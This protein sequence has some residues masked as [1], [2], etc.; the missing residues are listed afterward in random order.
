[1]R[2]ASFDEIQRII[3]ANVDK[4]VSVVYTDGTTKKLFVHTVDDEGFVCDLATETSEP[5]PC[6]YWVRF[7][8]VREVHPA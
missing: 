3:V 6:A 2:I 4:T 7:S 5:P 8:D 1:V